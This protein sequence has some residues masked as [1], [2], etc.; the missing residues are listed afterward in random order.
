[1]RG[2]AGQHFR[3]RGPSS[4]QF[5]SV[6]LLPRLYWNISSCLKFS[7]KAKASSSCTMSG[8]VAVFCELDELVGHPRA[9]NN[10]S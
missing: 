4:S 5:P 8:H 7:K 3:G 10:V 9:Y 6:L 1:M 2:S